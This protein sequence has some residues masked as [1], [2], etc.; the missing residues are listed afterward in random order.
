[1]AVLLQELSLLLQQLPL[2]RQLC[3]T[4]LQQS[5]QAGVG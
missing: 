4:L 5:L 3:V 2:C 1:V